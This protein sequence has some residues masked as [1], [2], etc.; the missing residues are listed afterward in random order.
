ME[1]RL[2]RGQADIAINY[3]GGLHHA[4]NLKLVDFV[5]L[6]ILYWDYRII[7]IS[8]QSIIY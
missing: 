3:A 5:I 4:K 8:P 6:M 2:N 1:A 7:T